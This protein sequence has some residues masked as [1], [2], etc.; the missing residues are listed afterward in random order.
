MLPQLVVSGLAQGVV[1]ALVALSMTM[2]YRATTVVNFGHG[3]L[4]MG[5]AFVVYVLVV[6][7]R[8]PYVI[9]GL[10]ALALL[11][12]LGVG[13]HQGLMRRIMSG[14]HLAIAM[15]ALAVGYALRGGARMLWGREVLP[16]PRIFPDRAWTLGDVVVTSDNLIVAGTVL[17]LMTVLF[18]LFNATRTGRL[19]RAVFQSQRGAALV[20]LNVDAVHRLMWGAGAA[21]A[22]LGGVLLAPITLLYP[23]MGVWVLVR[24]FAAMTLGGFGTLHGAVLGGLLL[25]V[26]ELVLGAYVST[27]F[28]DISAYVVVIVVLLL[29]PDGLFGRQLV[30]RV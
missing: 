5:G 8:L 23:D 1:Y 11:F 29:R 14:P 12:G 22:A 26:V 15:M 6:Y 30:V 21:L 9:G 16:F 10:L 4:V 25:G 3:D 13:I 18:V 7:A 28:I 2:V 17:G 24:G 27:A 20:G 19:L